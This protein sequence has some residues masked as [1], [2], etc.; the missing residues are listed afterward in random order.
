MRC[1]RVRDEYGSWR[2][3]DRWSFCKDCLDGVAY[4]AHVQSLLKHYQRVQYIRSI[5]SCSMWQFKVYVH[6]YSFGQYVGI[7]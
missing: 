6:D 1:R 7:K 5:A 3:T 2:D 4:H